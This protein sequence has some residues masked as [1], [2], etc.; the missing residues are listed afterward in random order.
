[1][2]RQQARRRSRE[3]FVGVG[4]AIL[5]L[6]VLVVAVFAIRNPRSGTHAAAAV[7]STPPSSSSPAAPSTSSTPAPKSPTLRPTDVVPITAGS[8]ARMTL[9]Q[10]QQVPL[11]VLNNTTITGL[12]A[13]AAHRF[14]L[15]GWT[16]TSFGNLVNDILSTCAYY[17]PS[18]PKAEAAARALKHEFPT[19]KRVR[20]R[21]PQLPAGPIVVVLTPDYAP[22]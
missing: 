19:I 18:D 8:S 16:V 20:P 2:A 14:R 3:R 1:M 9:A 11:I 5:G 12:A 10:A 6:V 21:F 13:Q 7:T 17:D 22:Q 15:S 4:L